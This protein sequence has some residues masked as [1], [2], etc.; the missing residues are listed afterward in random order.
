MP[1]RLLIAKRSIYNGDV[2]ANDMDAI[3]DSFLADL[4]RSTIALFVVTDPIGSVPV[5][6]AL[7]QKMEKIERTSVTKIA[8]ITAAGL[9]FLFAVA[10]T[11]ILTIFGITISSFMVAGG[12]LLFIVAIE[13]IT[14]GEWRF[15]GGGTRDES[16]VVPLAFPLLAGP[17]AITTVMI[18]YQTAGLL[19]TAI[20][21][22]IVIGFTYLVLTKV[23]RIYKVLGKRGSIVVTRVFA[24]LVAAI[25][26]QFIVDGIRDIFLV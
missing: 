3:S 25:A 11:Q 22:L 17:G 8:I 12:I 21:I 16:G 10:G 19:A 20:S 13:L 23:D 7:T 9:L 1:V 26:V 15:A 18:S 6:I 24:V 2:R 14:H 4:I 5:F